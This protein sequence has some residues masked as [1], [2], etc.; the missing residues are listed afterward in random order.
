VHLHTEDGV[1]PHGTWLLPAKATQI[2]IVFVHGRAVNSDLP[3]MRNI[4]GHL[5]ERGHPVLAANTRGRDFA[6]LLFM[7]DR[8]LRLGGASYEMFVE[9][10]HD[11]RA[12]IAAA[13]GPQGVVLMGHSYGCLKAVYYLANEADER[14][15]AL[16]LAAP[17]IFSYRQQTCPLRG[18]RASSTELD[19]QAC[20]GERG[21]PRRRSRSR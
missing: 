18:D 6:T 4:A 19:V 20:P 7:R 11:L 3:F 14:V 5:A 21:W 8:S 15:R 9:C 1:L 13:S 2:P 12:W 16:V 17:S 10:V